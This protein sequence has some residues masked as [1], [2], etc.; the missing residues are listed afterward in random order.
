MYFSYNYH[1]EDMPFVSMAKNHYHNG[2]IEIY[3]LEKG[4]CGYFIEDKTY[5][6]TSGD[7]IIIPEGVIHKTTYYAPYIRRLITLDNRALPILTGDEFSSITYVY[8]NY[9]IQG[10]I[11]CIFE[12]IHCEHSAP[13]K[14]TSDVVRLLVN[15]LVYLFVRNENKAGNT[16]L[17]SSFVAEAAR[18]ILEKYAED[19]TLDSVSRLLS[20]SPEHLS[21]SFKKDT[22]FGFNEYLNLVRLKKADELLRSSSKMSIFEIAISCGFN[23]SNYFSDKF[24]STYGISPTKYRK[25]IEK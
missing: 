8:R 6:V 13:D 17:S 20:V 21:R 10:E 2:L 25:G 3:Y 15:E 5:H 24:K 16:A 18:H 14:Y 19:I 11:K 9:D 23:D 22:G 1:S 4:E 12:K 7:V